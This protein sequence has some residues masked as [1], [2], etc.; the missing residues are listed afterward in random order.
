MIHSRAMLVRGYKGKSPKIGERVFIAETASVIGDVEIGEDS[1]IWYGT[2]IRADVQQI[3]IGA[4]TNVQDNCTLHVTRESA[5][6]LEDEVTLGHGVI[7]H[8]CVVRRGSLIG[9]GSR[10]LDG[11][12]VGEESIVAA[13]AL[14]SEGTI[15][16]P[17]SLVIGFP[18]KVRRTLTPEDLS[19]LVRFHRNYL[20]YKET[21]LGESPG[22]FR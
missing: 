13:G 5:L 16:P 19:Y 18:A 8:G 3:R 7:A 22:E 10:L 20:E 11:V 17:R 12:V 14:V 15:V 2:V 4:R 1:S 9:M 21:Y 6:L